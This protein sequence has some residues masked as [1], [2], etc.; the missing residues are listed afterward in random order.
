MATEELQALH[1]RR[2]GIGDAIRRLIPIA[3]DKEARDE[4]RLLHRLDLKDRL[5]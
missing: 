4:R 1:P 3:E 5:K 2:A